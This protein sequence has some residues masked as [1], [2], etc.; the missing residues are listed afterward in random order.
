MNANL[1]VGDTLLA[2]DLCLRSAKWSDP[3]AVAQL[4]QD[5]CVAEGDATLALSPEELKSGWQVSEFNMDRDTFVIET[6]DGRI[7]GY[8]DVTNSYEYAIYRMD[9]WA[10]PDFKGR[11]IGTSL[12]RAVEKRAREMM[13]FAEP[14]VRVSIQT[15]IGR[16]EQ[17]GVALHE[18]E[19][20]RP[21]QFR[22]RMEIVLDSAPAEPNWP[23]GIEP[24]PFIQGRHDEVVWQ[25]NNEAWRDEPGSHE[26]S[27]DKWRQYRFDDPEFDPS[28]W[29]IAWDGEEVAGYSLNRYRA[30]IGWIRAVGVRP[31]W[32]KRGIAKALL[33]H[34][35]GKYYRHGTRTIGADS[36]NP[37][38]AHRL[39]QKVGMVPASASVTYEKVLRAGRDPQTV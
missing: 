32:R 10:H 28:L 7:V 12:L 24:R 38:G 16:D 39:Y 15:T 13:R 31:K 18:N 37:M 23:E 8:A 22:L 35:F 4:I 6:F 20:Y 29:A 27:F 34:S 9:G 5:A 1:L 14:N 30:G 33:L 21:V 3:E 19:N 36:Q 17:D 26:W 11:G 25:A 2:P